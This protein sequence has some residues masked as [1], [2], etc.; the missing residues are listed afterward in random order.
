M[1]SITQIKHAAPER[2]SAPRGAPFD[3]Q[4]IL[5]HQERIPPTA[6]SGLLSKLTADKLGRRRPEITSKPVVPPAVPAKSKAREP[7]TAFTAGEAGR[8][9]IIETILSQQTTPQGRATVLYDA[10]MG[11]VCSDEHLTVLQQLLERG[12]EFSPNVIR[13]ALTDRATECACTLLRWNPEIARSGDGVDILFQ[14]AWMGSEE[15]VRVLLDLGVDPNGADTMGETPLH[16]AA[17]AA[18]GQRPGTIVHLLRY[19]ADV[20]G[21]ATRPGNAP[22]I[23]A[24]RRGYKKYVDV[25][26]AHRSKYAE[27][28]EMDLQ[29]A[30]LDGPWD[31]DSD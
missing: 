25:F 26:L 17:V 7:K 31:S 30:I 4:I 29:R 1:E 24:A 2:S 22:V 10:L 11:V 18:N 5:Q 9:D 28:A 3:E 16:R 19:G 15:T 8:R 6:E 23:L 13:R 20:D 21:G 12:A 14:A 27:I